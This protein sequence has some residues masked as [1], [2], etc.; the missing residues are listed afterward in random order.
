MESVERFRSSRFFRDELAKLMAFYHPR[1]IDRA[2][3]YFQF[4]DADGKVDQPQTK[5]LVSSARIVINYAMAQRHLGKPEFLDAIRHGLAFLRDGHRNTE[6]GGYAWVLRDGQVVDATNHCYGLAFV[7][8]AYARALQAGVDEAREGIYQTWE[9]L[10]RRFWEAQ[11]GL[12]ADEASAD[13]V[14]SSYR[15]QN[16]NMHLCEALIAAWEATG[17]K[18]F[19][20]RAAAVADKMVNGLASQCRGQVWEHYQSDWQIDWNYNRGDRSNIFRPWG[21]Q[22]GHQIEWAK[23]LL[24]LDR[25]APEPWRLRRTCEL[26]TVA[27]DLA[28]DHQHG[29]L[30]YG[31][32]PAGQ[33]YDND[34][35]SWVQVEAL[36]TSALLFDRTGQAQFDDWYGR[37][38]AYCW[39]VFVDPRSGCW[40]RIRKPDNSEVAEPAPFSGLTDYHTLSAYSDLI[41]VFGRAAS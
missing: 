1:C 21:L 30:I 16:A 22:P 40:Y 32:D 5:H 20:D 9:L 7:M 26:F 36:A 31:Y 34:K 23:L 38:A 6:A 15:G 8:L 17:D 28:W 4:F 3:G 41:E 2:G 39:P 37:I 33:P 25:I 12:Y 14:L 24:Q 27:V 11:H 29:G 18:M 35:Y 13:W 10:E 19:A